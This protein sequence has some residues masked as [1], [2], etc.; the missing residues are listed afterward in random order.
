[1]LRHH[2][3][4]TGDPAGALAKR[5]HRVPLGRALTP[6]DVARA[7]LYLSCDDSA[8]V[9]GTSLVVDGGYLTAAEWET[10]KVTLPEDLS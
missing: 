4:A 2:L 10:A 7:V 3:H 6:G 1:M 8:G 9:T 5:L